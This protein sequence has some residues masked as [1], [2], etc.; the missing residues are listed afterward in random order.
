M[1]ATPQGPGWWQ[2]EDGLWHPPPATRPTTPPPMPPTY[3]GPGLVPRRRTGCGLATA[4]VLALLAG[5][6]VLR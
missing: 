6:G 4:F 1:S 5:A 2:D 3:G